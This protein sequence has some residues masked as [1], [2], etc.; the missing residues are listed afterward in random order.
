MIDPAALQQF[1]LALPG[2]EETARAGI[3]VFRV[4][5]KVFATINPAAHRAT[6]KLTPEDQPV[7]MAMGQGVIY[8]VPNYWGKLGW[9]HLDLEKATLEMC[10]DALQIA[11]YLAAPAAL[12]AKHPH[13]SG[14]E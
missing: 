13:L 9:T 14:L 5:K 3:Q 1:A 8:P 11:W 12:L 6:V 4:K 7:F 10:Q 2:T